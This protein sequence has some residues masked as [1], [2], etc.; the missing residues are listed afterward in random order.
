MRNK[1]RSEGCITESYLVEESI[2]FFIDFLS[3]VNLIGL[4][5]CKSQDHLDTSNIGRPL[6]MEVPFKPE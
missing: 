6:S 4:G 5:T 3:E 2:D 1:Y